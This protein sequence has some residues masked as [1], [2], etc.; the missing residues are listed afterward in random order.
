MNNLNP[1]QINSQ[2]TPDKR[3]DEINDILEKEKDLKN[4]LNIRLKYVQEKISTLNTTNPDNIQLNTYIEEESNIKNELDQLTQNAN[5]DL[6]NIIQVKDAVEKN[7]SLIKDVNNNTNNSTPSIN[8]VKQPNVIINNWTY[9][10]EKTVRNWIIALSKL[11][12]I[13]N[14]VYE[15]NKKK[16]NI[17]L[18][19]SL[20]ITSITTLLSS[21]NF[22]TTT[23]GKFDLNWLIDLVLTIN[24]FLGTLSLIILGIIK[25]MDYP[26]ITTQLASYYKSIDT[27][28]NDMKTCLLLN[29]SLRLDAVTFITTHNKT[30]KSLIENVPEM[31]NNDIIKASKLYFKYSNN[32]IANY[33]ITLKYFT[34]QELSIDVV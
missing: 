7:L 21:I 11:S 25:I 26:T 23:V 3:V 13:V 14:Y 1:K 9:N 33:N 28:C 18:I 19:I 4:E 10:N 2:T 5:H 27:F 34:N 24:T 16:Y 15:Q 32:E 29:P 6:T 12:F 30:Y 31:S 20:I 22:G 17:Y 8:F